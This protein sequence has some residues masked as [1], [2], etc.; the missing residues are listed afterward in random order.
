MTLTGHFSVLI[1]TLHAKV[2][3]EIKQL[4]LLSQGPNVILQWG[5][6]IL[7]LA[8]HLHDFGH[9]FMPVLLLLT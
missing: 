6:Q 4:L 8:C 1:L 5:F 3:A 9:I 2:E 7:E